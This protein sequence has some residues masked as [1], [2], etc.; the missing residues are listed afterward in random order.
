[1]F[2][3]IKTYERMDN[4]SLP[5]HLFFSSAV[6]PVAVSLDSRYDVLK[7][8]GGMEKKRS[9]GVTVVGIALI[10]YCLWL[11][12]ASGFVW[13]LTHFVNVTLPFLKRPMMVFRGVPLMTR[14]VAV[15]YL[16]CA[17]GI[18]SLKKW[19]HLLFLCFTGLLMIPSIHVVVTLI[20]A[21]A[22]GELEGAG[23]IALLSLLGV[24]PYLLFLIPAVFLLLPQVR[25]QFA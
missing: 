2:D 12:L 21:A 19:A 7:K 8:G 14:S 18:L 11:L 6:H 15:V 9:T 24:F 22:K 5:R 3:I 20:V 17:V 4:V 23:A 13:P 1:M 25:R 16:C 10:A